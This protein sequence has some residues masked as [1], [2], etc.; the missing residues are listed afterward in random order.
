V[1]ARAAAHV[2]R[3]DATSVG[4]VGLEALRLLHGT[5]GPAAERVVSAALAQV[6]ERWEGDAGANRAAAAALELRGAGGEADRRLALAV[7]LGGVCPSGKRRRE[8][9]S[10]GA[11]DAW[12]D[13]E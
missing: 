2:S 11:D 6:R 3:V 9:D 12:R 10:E 5:G 13:D 1:A 4:V 7:G 8:P